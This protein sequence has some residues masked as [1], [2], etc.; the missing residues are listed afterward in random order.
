MQCEVEVQFQFYAVSPSHSYPSQ[1]LSQ[2]AR[3]LGIAA[4]EITTPAV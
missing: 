4:Q 3:S 1:L 2:L